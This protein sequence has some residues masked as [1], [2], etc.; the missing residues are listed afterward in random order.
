MSATHG[1]SEH[2]MGAS[3][4]AV[5]QPPPGPPD[6]LDQSQALRLSA[7]SGDTQ[8]VFRLD[9]D[10]PFLHR[11]AEAAGDRLEWLS[12]NRRIVIAA[13]VAVLA[14]VALT[15]V[16]GGAYRGHPLPAAPPAAAAHPAPVV[17]PLPPAPAVPGIPPVPPAAAAA[18]APVIEEIPE[19][20]PP[21][22]AP[23]LHKRRVRL[24]PAPGKSPAAIAH[25]SP[26]PTT[27]PVRW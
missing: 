15:G 26:R 22:P 8:V 12:E 3:L 24:A 2:S 23:R 4:G 17:L 5:P 6:E 16:I 13:V 18:T 25:P 7:R 19:P 10:V 9:R 11:L 14:V 1:P 20:P 27:A 21:P